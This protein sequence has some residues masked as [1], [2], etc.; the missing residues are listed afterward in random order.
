MPLHRVAPTLEWWALDGSG[1]RQGTLT[2]TA[3]GASRRA[4]SIYW[5]ATPT[6]TSMRCSI[7]T[8]LTLWLLAI[9]PVLALRCAN[10]PLL[11]AFGKPGD[12][13]QKCSGAQ[14][15]ATKSA[16]CVW[17]ICGGG[18]GV[19]NRTVWLRKSTDWGTTWL[20]PVP[21][22]HL[23]A[24]DLGQFIYDPKTDTILSM[25]P[26][27]G[28]FPRGGPCLPSPGCA[29]PFS[30]MSKSTDD[31]T[32]LTIA[33]AVGCHTE[34]QTGSTGEGCGGITLSTGDILAPA[35]RKTGAGNFVIISQDSGRTWK[36]GNATP[37]LPSKRRVSDERAN[38]SLSLR[39]SAW[40]LYRNDGVPLYIAGLALRIN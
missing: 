36:M 8:A 29:Q 14:V 7:R 21:Q 39:N 13:A 15:V 10:A 19:V 37:P 16:L 31:G 28:P 26:P 4:R 35:G 34:N 12:D 3:Q 32:S 27:P 1:L 5:P 25:S 30:C 11:D 6:T 38:L 17:G 2:S 20:A 23:G 33:E 40:A 24:G 9:G 22:P 18:A